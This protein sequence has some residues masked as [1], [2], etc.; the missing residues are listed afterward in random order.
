MGF[1]NKFVLMVFSLLILS[2]AAYSADKIGT[3]GAPNSS[4]VY[5]LEVFDNRVIKVASDANINWT[6]VVMVGTGI[7]WTDTKSLGSG[8]NWAELDFQAS[9]GINWQDVYSNTTKGKTAKKA[10]ID[11]DGNLYGISAGECF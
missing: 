6:D 5:P 8:V 9:S 3:M 10:C 2:V 4:G 7:N 11:T 1:R